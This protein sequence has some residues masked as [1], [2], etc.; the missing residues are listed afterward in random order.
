MHHQVNSIT[1][2]GRGLLHDFVRVQDEDAGKRCVVDGFPNKG[3][4]RY[5]LF[6][7]TH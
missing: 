3:V 1:V 2:R 4:M 7:F 5:N 6:A